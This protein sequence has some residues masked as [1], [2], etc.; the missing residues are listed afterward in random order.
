MRKLVVLLVVAIMAIN[1]SSQ[2]KQES[3]QINALEK[4]IKKTF[5][6]IDVLAKDSLAIHR[7]DIFHLTYVR[8]EI[9]RKKQKIADLQN[10]RDNIFLSFAT[11]RELSKE[12]SR[13]EVK[14]RQRGNYLRRQ[15]LVLEKVEAN[16]SSIDPSDLLGTDRGYKVI[17]ANDYTMT[18]TF[19]IR[20]VDGGEGKSVVVTP[21]E[22]VN[23]YLVPGRYLVS[24][25][26]GSAAAYTDKQLTIDG[27]THIFKGEDCFNF[28]YMP[29]F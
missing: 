15:E 23:V 5:K 24:T 21:R 17:V 29:R 14:L 10:E 25:L 22:K 19:V 9:D 16:L 18:V 7:A 28:I 13:R 11:T 12:A 3:K 27:S 1:A 4:E 20:P 8:N 26:S 6:E 2:T